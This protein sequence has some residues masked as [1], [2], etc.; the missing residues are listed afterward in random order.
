MTSNLE[1]KLAISQWLHERKFEPDMWYEPRAIDGFALFPIQRVKGSWRMSAPFMSLNR[2]LELLP[3]II[4]HYYALLI[5]KDG[6]FYFDSDYKSLVEE[7]VGNI[8][9][10]L[11]ALRLLKKVIEAGYLKVNK[12]DQSVD[13]DKEKSTDD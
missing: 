11:A 6:C 7:R 4:E 9:H 2:A 1:E 13:F 5:N 3:D 12:T 8:D 10:E